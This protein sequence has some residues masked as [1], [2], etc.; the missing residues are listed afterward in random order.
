MKI[1]IVSSA[2]SGSTYLYEVVQQYVAPKQLT[3]TRKH[4]DRTRYDEAIKDD[5]SA[6]RNTNNVDVVLQQPTWV[7][8]MLVEDLNDSNCDL[9]MQ[10]VRCA[11]I[12]V[13]LRRN[14]AERTLSRLVANQDDKWGPKRVNTEHIEIDYEI[15]RKEVKDTIDSEARLNAQPADIVLDYTQLE[16]PRQIIS[17]ITG[18]PQHK[19]PPMLPPTMK[20]DMVF[21]G[22][23]L[24]SIRD[25]MD[26]ACHSY[27]C[28][29]WDD[30]DWD[31]YLG[32]K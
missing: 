19:F 13:K 17:D 30:W 16:Y 4:A 27:N 8:K 9:Y 14:P 24:L 20:N 2:R 21:D 22:A 18:M 25:S 1:L 29:L 23:T 32:K 28:T 11:D 12:V 15:V 6:V 10:L 31:R 7:V 3:W 5:L 26:A